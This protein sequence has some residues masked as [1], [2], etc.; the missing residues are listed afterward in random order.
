MEV[1]GF[2]EIENF[3]IRDYMI[4]DSSLITEVLCCKARP[5]YYLQIFLIKTTYNNLSF[6]FLILTEYN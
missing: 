2:N 5:R 6:C 4:T 3:S 1:I